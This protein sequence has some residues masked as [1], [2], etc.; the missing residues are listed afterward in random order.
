[1]TQSWIMFSL[2]PPSVESLNLYFDLSYAIELSKDSCVFILIL[3]HAKSL[4]AS[5]DQGNKR[6]D[7]VSM[8]DMQ[9]RKQKGRCKNKEI[10]LHQVIYKKRTMK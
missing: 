10:K 6:T 4:G 5:K 7:S 2:F 3:P 1:M 9:D 8:H